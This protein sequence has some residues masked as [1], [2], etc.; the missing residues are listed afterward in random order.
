[1]P[2]DQALLT[3]L[4]KHASRHPGVEPGVACPGTKI[5]ST[6]YNVHGKS[7]LFVRSAPDRTELR[8]KLA[9]SVAEAT[10]LARKDPQGF[11]VGSQGWTKIVFLTGQAPAKNLLERWIDESHA[12]FATAKAPA[13]KRAARK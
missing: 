11:T 2:T 1:M 12:L 10:A 13:K 8:L 5:E 6:T 3:A 7:F 9:A 4:A